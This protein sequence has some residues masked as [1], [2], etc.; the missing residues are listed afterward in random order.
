MKI[1]EINRHLYFIKK[2]LLY[3]YYYVNDN[4]VPAWFFG[5]GHTVVSTRSF[6]NQVPSHACIEVLED[7]ELYYFTKEKFDCAKKTFHE[8]SLIANELYP[9]Y[10]M[11]FERYA[12]MIRYYKAKEKYQFLLSE[13]P[14]LIQQVPV[15]LLAP[16]L[17]MREATL[18]RMRSRNG[19]KNK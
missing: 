14:E 2:G 3:S 6:Y 10:V 5:P 11:E 15:K 7:C 17:G 9:K 1:G 13:R 19:G 16:W 12:E 8:F 18:S 4:P